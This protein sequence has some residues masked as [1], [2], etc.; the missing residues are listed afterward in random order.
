MTKCGRVTN[1]KV[2]CG[3]VVV[4]LPISGQ[5]GA[6]VQPSFE[7]TRAA[8]G[9]GDELDVICIKEAVR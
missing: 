7:T 4:Q 5:A 6:A 9:G 1:G 3:G 8:R 2:G